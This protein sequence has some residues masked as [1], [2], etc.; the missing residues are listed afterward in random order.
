M[1]DKQMRESRLEAVTSSYANLTASDTGWFGWCKAG[2]PSTQDT[3]SGLDTMGARNQGL[4]EA[5]CLVNGA[6]PAAQAQDNSEQEICQLQFCM[7]H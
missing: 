5:P 2:A 3:S 1:G 4:H 7:A 6:D